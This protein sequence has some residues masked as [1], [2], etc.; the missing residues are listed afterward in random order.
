[1]Y[2]G[3]IV[4]QADEPSTA[5]TAQPEAIDWRTLWAAGDLGQFCF[6]SLGILLHATNETMVA[7]ILP[8]MIRDLFGVELAG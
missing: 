8:A 6:V 2:A 4:D 1:M 7:T 5:N 3:D